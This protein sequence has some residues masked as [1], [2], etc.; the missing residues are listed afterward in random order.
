MKKYIGLVSV[1]M[2]SLFSC[3]E[4]GISLYSDS[5]YVS[6]VKNPDS[7]MDTTA[8]SFFFYSQAPEV[9]VPIEVAITGELLKEDTEFKVIIDEKGTS[10]DQSLIVVDDFYTFTKGEVI[11][12][13]N[14]TFKNHESLQGN[15]EYLKLRI[16]DA[17]NLLSVNTEEYATTVFSISAS[18]VQPSWWIEE[19]EWY[20]LGVYSEIKYKYLIEVTGVSDFSDLSDSEQRIHAI[21]LKRFLEEKAAAGETIYEADGVTPVTVAAVG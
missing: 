18:A 15:T 9:Q 8:F 17:E 20:I 14:V 12:T 11:S 10:V 21:A 16:V 3:Q 13:I 2:I 5:N 1:L 6:F 19:V 4:Q 7:P